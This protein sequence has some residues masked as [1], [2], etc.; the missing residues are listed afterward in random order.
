MLKRGDKKGQE[1]ST[2]VIILIIL[3]V[4]VLVVLILGFT[5]GW[6]K[7]APW[8]SS[9]NVDSIKTQCDVACSTGSDYDY[10]T[11][12]RELNDGT[13][14]IKTGCA[15]FSVINDYTKYGIKKCPALTCNI[16]CADVKVGTRTAI[17][18]ASVC[19]IASDDITSIAKITNT[20]NKFCCIAKQ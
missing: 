17:E 19:D 11:K 8:L 15:T 14:K 16:P 13:N 3:G 2:N 1:L 20:N 18:Q 7:I 10:C 4:V 9:E 5:V 6:G 12:E